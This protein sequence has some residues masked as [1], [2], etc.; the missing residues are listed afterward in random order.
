[1]IAQLFA[2]VRSVLAGVRNHDLDAEM[3][4]E[5]AH[6]IELRTRDLVKSGV[7][8]EDA[9][10]RA[11]VEFGGTYNH[12]LAGR[13]AR[14]LRWLDAFR[15]SWLDVRLGA[16]MIRRYPGL[17][18]IGGLAM[19]VAIAL[20]A[21]V[22][23]VIALINDPEIPLHE[24]ERIAGIQVWHTGSNNAERRIAYDLAVWKSELTTVR[25]IGAFRN[26]VRAVGANDGRA[27]PGRGAEICTMTTSVRARL[28]WWCW[29][30]SSGPPASAP[31]RPSW[32]GR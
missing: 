23:S 5:F 26:A 3:E 14:G 13:E 1:M 27:E 10:R 29:V 24:G 6:H 8:S 25:D 32:A 20:G 21:G 19:G 9:A 17:T 30:T 18:V 4:A 16:R 12:R 11:R 2:R 28:S 15:I 7:P 22:L 31:T